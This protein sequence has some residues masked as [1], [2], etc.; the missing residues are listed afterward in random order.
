MSE[1]PDTFSYM[2]SAIIQSHSVRD[3][4]FCMVLVL[5]STIISVRGVAQTLTDPFTVST[6]AAK[7]QFFLSKYE[8]PLK[9]YNYQNAAVNEM[10][11][12]SIMDHQKTETNCTIGAILATSGFVMMVV[13][14]GDGYDIFNSSGD[15][16]PGPSPEVLI[17]SGMMGGSVPFFM[18]SFKNKRKMKESIEE[19]KKLLLQPSDTLIARF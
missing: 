6:M 18:S 5:S 9:N 15:K 1:S 4:T 13:G 17:G 19:T 14:L 11:L 10:L 7:D 12:Q 3:F 16:I 2:K 8:V